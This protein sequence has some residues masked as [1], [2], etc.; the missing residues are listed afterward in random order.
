VLSSWMVA[1]GTAGNVIG[2]APLAA[3]AQAFGWRPSMAALGVVTLLTA[4]AIAFFLR[5]PPKSADAPAGSSGLAG[6][7]ELFSLRALWPLFPLTALNYAPPTGI[8]GL[9]SVHISATS[10]ARTRSS[11]ARSPCSWR[12]PWSAAPSSTGRS[13]PSSAHANGSPPSAIP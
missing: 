12:S 7:R 13:T 8:R 2:A 3:A 4:A 10:T 5:D 11:S 9:W 6:Y 1:F